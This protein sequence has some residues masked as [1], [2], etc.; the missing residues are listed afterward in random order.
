MKTLNALIALTIVFTGLSAHAASVAADQALGERYESSTLGPS[1]IRIYGIPSGEDCGDLKYQVVQYS[2]EFQLFEF[3]SIKWPLKYSPE[4]GSSYISKGSWNTPSRQICTWDEAKLK[5]YIQHNTPVWRGAKS[6]LIL[7]RM[8]ADGTGMEGRAFVQGKDIAQITA[9]G[10]NTVEGFITF[11]LKSCVTDRGDTVTSFTDLD[12][13]TTDVRDI[14]RNLRTRGYRQFLK[15]TLTVN[16]KNY[17]LDT[18]TDGETVAPGYDGESFRSGFNGEKIGYDNGTYRLNIQS[19]TPD[20]LFLSNHNSGAMTDQYARTAQ[21]RDSAREQVALK[22]MKEFVSFINNDYANVLYSLNNVKI[23]Q[24]ERNEAIR[25]FF[26]KNGSKIKDLLAQVDD[27]YADV[28]LMNKISMM[29]SVQDSY[30]TIAKVEKSITSS[31]TIS[32]DQVVHQY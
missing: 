1:N 11:Q 12:T 15:C 32:L 28:S 2:T 27:N 16:P 6:G 24:A 10:S 18:L 20:R 29:I 30:R 8:T 5:A 22:A 21:P 13:K 25:A 9:S 17:D 23:S 4:Y 19:T 26:E 14:I 7:D 31:S 3:R